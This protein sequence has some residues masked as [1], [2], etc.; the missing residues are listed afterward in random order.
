MLSHRDVYES[1]R[2][3]ART[4]ARGVGLS[5]V[6]TVVVLL[7][8]FTITKRGQETPRGTIAIVADDLQTRLGL[9]QIDSAREL[10]TAF[11]AK[12]D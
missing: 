7:C 1:F 12:Q 11:S 2:S 3:F 10:L 6:P 5:I 9:S 4:L 8:I